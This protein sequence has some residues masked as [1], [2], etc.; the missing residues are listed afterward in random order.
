MN[1]VL[2]CVSA[3]VL[4]INLSGC[5]IVYH[6]QARETAALIT[7]RLQVGMSTEQVRSAIG[8]PSDREAYKDQE[9]WFYKTKQL[10]TDGSRKQIYTPVVFENGK[11]AGWGTKYHNDPNVQ[12][13]EAD[14]TVKHK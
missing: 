8:P 13:Y 3:L 11:V 14:I 10:G 2:F 7:E 1:K 9:I 4:T 6:Y 12:K 5:G